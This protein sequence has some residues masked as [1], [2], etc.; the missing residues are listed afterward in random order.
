MEEADYQ[1]ISNAGVAFIG[2]NNPGVYPDITASATTAQQER[3]VTD[4]KAEVAVY[5]K[6]LSVTYV[7]KLK[8]CEAVESITC[9]LILISDV[10]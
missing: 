1:E 6:C 9:I 10:N 7:L 4:Y 2:L 8:I 3:L 5:E